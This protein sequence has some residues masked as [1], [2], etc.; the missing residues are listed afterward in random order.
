M[1]GIKESDWRIFRELHDVALERFC[2]RVLEGVERLSADSAKTF[3]SATS[4]FIATP[5]SAKEN[6]QPPSTT[7]AGRPLCSSLLVFSVTIC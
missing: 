4:T 1:S 5:A 3:I 2:R 7:R 6:C